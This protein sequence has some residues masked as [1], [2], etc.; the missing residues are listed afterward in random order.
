MNLK[1]IALATT[2]I[3]APIG[4]TAAT[5]AAKNKKADTQITQQASD[6]QLSSQDYQTY[7]LPQFQKAEIEPNEAL[8]FTH[9]INKFFEL[10]EEKRDSIINETVTKSLSA[11]KNYNNRMDSIQN[12][13]DTRLEELSDKIIKAEFK[14][15]NLNKVLTDAE[16][17]K[18]SIINLYNKMNEIDSITNGAKAVKVLPEADYEEITENTLGMSLEEFESTYT[19]ELAS[20]KDRE[21]PMNEPIPSPYMLTEKERFVLDKINE[22]NINLNTEFGK[23]YLNA[24]SNTVARSEKTI[25][26]VYSAI[27]QLNDFNRTH[28]YSDFEDF[29]KNESPIVIKAFLT[30]LDKAANI[31]TGTSSVTADKQN[32]PSVRKYID[33]GKVIIEVKNPNNQSVK[34]YTTNGIEAK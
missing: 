12:V 31:T 22:L 6:Y 8:P 5:V 23:D 3:A 17:E 1:G 25:D 11:V 16:E 32:Q 29:I 24:S 9:I 7:V 26:D 2:L 20:L 18:D 19:E 15:T 14:E 28:Q 4:A 13:A 30:E 21:I 34:K 33:D 10:S 27:S